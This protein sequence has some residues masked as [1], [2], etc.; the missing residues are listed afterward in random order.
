MNISITLRAS[1]NLL[2]GRPTFRTQREIN[3]VTLTEFI[4]T[5]LSRLLP[6][7][8]LLNRGE[9][10]VTR[11][12]LALTRHEDSSICPIEIQLYRKTKN[13]ANRFP[14]AKISRL[15]EERSEFVT[16]GR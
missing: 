1:M 7:F 6:T 2:H 9:H 12:Y 3:R 13:I 10:N 4:H 14:K 16:R 11:I 8:T 5:L 15:G